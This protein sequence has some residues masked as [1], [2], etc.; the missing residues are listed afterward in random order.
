[1]KDGLGKGKIAGRKSSQN[2]LVIK[3]KERERS[4]ASTMNHSTKSTWQPLNLGAL[5]PNLSSIT[6]PIRK[7]GLI[8]S[9]SRSHLSGLVPAP[10]APSVWEIVTSF[11]KQ[12]TFCDLG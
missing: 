6:A 7:E 4:F 3:E 1:M 9:L 12:I 11:P 8:T 5:S 10:A 2:S